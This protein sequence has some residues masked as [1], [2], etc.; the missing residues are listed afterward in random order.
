MIKEYYSYED[1]RRDLRTLTKKI[2]KP[3]D[4]IMGISRGGLSMAQMLGEYYNI[5]KVYAIN[6][7]GYDDTIKLDEVRIFN[8]P[9]LSDSKAV[10][11]VDDILDSGETMVKVLDILKEKYPDV[12]LYVA[13]I[14]YKKS[15]KI[16]PDWF[17]KEPQNWID[18]FWTVDLKEDKV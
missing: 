12:I 10:L 16:A 1:F 5:R 3:F 6:S 17:V 15:A 11:I 9:D 18:F 2:N 8:T 13:S 14:F 4:T 7:I